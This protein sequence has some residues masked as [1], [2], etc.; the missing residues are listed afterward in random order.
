[1]AIINK[2]N[3]FIVREKPEKYTKFEE[4]N[5]N[6]GQHLVNRKKEK[7]YEFYICDNCGC[8]IKIDKKW[9]NNKGGIL[10]IPKTLSKMNKT[11]DIAICSKCLNEVLKEFEERKN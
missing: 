10:R 11:F 3:E 8:E 7:L 5:N 2:L 4:S 9:E 6:L 1:M